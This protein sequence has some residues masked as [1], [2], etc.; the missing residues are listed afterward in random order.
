MKDIYIDVETTGTDHTK[1]GIHQLS[2]IIVIDGVERESFNFNIAPFPY[3][4]IVPEAVAVSGRTVEQ[5][6]TYPAPA[7][8]YKKLTTILRT[9]VDKYNKKDKFN[10]IGYNSTFDSQFVRQF[11]SNN[12]DP[13]YGSWFWTPD[14]D[15]MRVAGL[16]LRNERP[17]MADFKLGT[18]ASYLGIDMTGLALHDA[19]ADIRITM[20][21]HHEL[22][23]RYSQ[24]AATSA[25]AGG[26]MPLIDVPAASE[27][28]STD[29]DSSPMFG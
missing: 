15:I 9:Y 29:V 10:F 21:M 23:R 2:G 5:V 26:Q 18:V 25:A 6:K 27:P 7:E 20:A 17:K 28:V 22:E 11:F 3:Q 4:E 1:H 19:M 13:Y 16:L 8:I 12:Q 14:I 24:G